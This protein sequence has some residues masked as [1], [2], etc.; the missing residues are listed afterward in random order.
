M[1]S[2][3]HIHIL[4]GKNRYE[5]YPERSAGV[6]IKPCPGFTLSWNLTDTSA[7]YINSFAAKITPAAFIH[8]QGGYTPEDTRFA[9]SLTILL[10]HLNVSYSISSHPYLGYTHSFGITLSAD[11]E[12]ET[13]RYS[14][15]SNFTHDKKVNINSAPDE[16]IKNLP[17]LS[18]RSSE[19]IIIYRKKIGPVSEKVLRSLGLDNNEILSVKTNCYGLARNVHIKDDDISSKKPGWKRK[20]FIS[21]RERVKERFRIMIKLGVPASAAIR[22]SEIPESPSRA[23]SNLLYLMT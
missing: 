18:R 14:T 19:R 17:G 4:T 12:I 9:A 3:Q 10:K 5:L 20:S 16:D 23:I 21:S 6:L 22:Y 1:C 2:E 8:L 11:S 13:I 15:P 7:G